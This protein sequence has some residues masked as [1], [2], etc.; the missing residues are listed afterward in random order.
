MTRRRLTGQQRAAKERI[1][2]GMQ[3]YVGETERLLGILDN[4]LKDTDYLVGNKYSIA[5]IASFGWVNLA[6]FS[7]VDI[8]QFPSLTAWWKRISARPAVQKGVAIPKA[9]LNSNDKYIENLKND[10]EFAKREGDLYAKIDAAK[11]QYGYKYASP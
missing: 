2:Y 9:P 3:R 7:G 11:Q 6:R 1:P 5:D 10:P 4:A 8:D